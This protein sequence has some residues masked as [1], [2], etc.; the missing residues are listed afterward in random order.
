MKIKEDKKLASNYG[1]ACGD[2]RLILGKDDKILVPIDAKSD[3]LSLVHLTHRKVSKSQPNNKPTIEIVHFYS[4]DNVNKETE[5]IIRTFV[6]KLDENLQLKFQKVD[7]EPVDLEDMYKIFVQKAI[8][9]GLNKVAVPETLDFLDAYTFGKM[10]DDGVFSPPDVLEAKKY[11]PDQPEIFIIR[12][13]CY[14]EDRFFESFMR[15]NGLEEK[16][17]GINVK[18][19]P[20]METC[21]NALNTLNTDHNNAKRNFFEAQFN[22][23]TK[24]L[25]QGEAETT[26]LN[27]DED[28]IWG[29]KEERATCNHN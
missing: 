21:V 4:T 9:L 18:M 20:T 7:R 11:G 5:E 27:G 16:P 22:V 12:P 13:L 3:Y 8:E 26:E 17:G 19:S 1:K 2:F 23:Q 29:V 24:Y 6:E 15:I 14:I 25:G 28:I 10:C